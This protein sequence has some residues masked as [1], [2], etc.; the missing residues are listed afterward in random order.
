MRRVGDL[1]RRVFARRFAA[2]EEVRLLAFAAPEALEE[3]ALTTAAPEGA[4]APAPAAPRCEFCGT[5]QAD[6]AALAAHH[7]ACGQRRWWLRNFGP[8]RQVELGAGAPVDVGI[9]PGLAAA[10]PARAGAAPRAGLWDALTGRDRD[11]LVARIAA[12]EARLATV[13]DPRARA[14]AEGGVGALWG[15]AAAIAEGGPAGGLLP[16]IRP[17]L[18][19]CANAILAVALEVEAHA[20][21]LAHASARELAAQLEALRARAARTTRPELREELDEMV[22]TKSALLAER[23]RLAEATELLLLRLE[24]MTDR[25]RATHAKVLRLAAT[26][27]VAEPEGRTQVAVFFDTLA[28]EVGLMAD[29]VAEVEATLAEEP[30]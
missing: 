18:I 15:M 5:D 16:R 23:D 24:S 30:P 28:R 12:V 6:A 11:P 8:E 7:D 20:A 22:R 27:M 14:L 3:E 4:A 13:R 29:S 21:Y 17:E 2:R 10:L 26:P 25:V 1:L 19:G 9:A